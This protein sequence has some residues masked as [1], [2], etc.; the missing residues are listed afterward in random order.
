MLR[1]LYCQLFKGFFLSRAFSFDSYF[2]SEMGPVGPFHGEKLLVKLPLLVPKKEAQ[3]FIASFSSSADRR[4]FRCA[5]VNSWM[6]NR[7]RGI[8]ADSFS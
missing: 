6:K 4:E 1:W 2:I 5:I 8:V 7:D 3:H